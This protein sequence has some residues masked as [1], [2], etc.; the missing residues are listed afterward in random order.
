MLLSSARAEMTAL[1]KVDT[2]CT[3]P[4]LIPTVNDNT[5]RSFSTHGQQSAAQGSSTTVSRSDIRLIQYLDSSALGFGQEVALNC[6]FPIH[7]LP[8]PPRGTHRERGRVWSCFAT[9]DDNARG[10]NELPPTLVIACRQS[11][12]ATGTCVG[13]S[14]GSPCASTHASTALAPTPIPTRTAFSS[15]AG[16]QAGACGSRCG[17]PP[18]S[19]VQKLNRDFSPGSNRVLKFQEEF[20]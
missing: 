19:A 3:T 1:P 16:G 12:A 17:A 5:V 2:K 10:G 18:A 13:M 14:S 8:R 6:Y 11:T 9:A 20:Q 15:P 7:V 4:S